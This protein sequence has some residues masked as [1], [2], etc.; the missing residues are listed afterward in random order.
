MRWQRLSAARRKQI[1]KAKKQ[2]AGKSYYVPTGNPRG[3]P[4]KVNK[5]EAIAMYKQGLTLEKIGEHF[6]VTRERIRQILV[7]EGV[8]SFDGGRTIR[9]FL[10]TE[11]KRTQKK[12]AIQKKENRVRKSW[13]LSLDEYDFIKKNFGASGQPGSPF[14]RFVCQ[15]KN[16]R[17]RKVKWDISFNDWWRIWQESGHYEKYGRGHG[18]YCMA[19]WGDSGPYSKDN[20]KIIA[21]D[22]N[23]SEANKKNDLP[24]GVSKRKNTFF[25]QTM[26]NKKSVYLGSFNNAEDA[27]IA[28]QKAIAK[29]A[30]KRNAK[31]NAA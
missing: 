28:Y 8:S 22:D 18:K 7:K 23:N 24:R 3:A 1:A 6:A 4:S 27:S 31:A 16:A 10:D 19:R 17:H 15:R 29:L 13:G 30:R 26:I 2:T 21:S 12:D 11:K 14:T 25:A 5:A 20:V 9:C